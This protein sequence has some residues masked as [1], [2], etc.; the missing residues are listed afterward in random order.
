MKEVKKR[1]M[2]WGRFLLT[3]NVDEKMDTSESDVGGTTK[4]AEGTSEATEDGSGP[5]G[6]D[7]SRTEGGKRK[8]RGSDGGDEKMDSS[9]SDVVSTTNVAEAPPDTTAD[10]KGE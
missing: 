6:D 7:K 9:E 4:L 3:A 5:T 10:E 2:V 1:L 8:S